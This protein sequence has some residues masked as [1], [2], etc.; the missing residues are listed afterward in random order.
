MKKLIISVAYFINIFAT[1]F[2]EKS[3]FT[4]TF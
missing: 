2:P 1:I 3:A 4:P